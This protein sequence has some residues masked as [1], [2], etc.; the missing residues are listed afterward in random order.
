MLPKHHRPANAA[1]KNKVANFDCSDK[2]KI[3]IN[4]GKDI[5]TVLKAVLLSK[6][7]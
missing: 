1:I 3:G 5:R 6:L 7:T 4:N 2:K